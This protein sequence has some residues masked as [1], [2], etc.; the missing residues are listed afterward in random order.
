MGDIGYE[1]ARELWNEAKKGEK[2]IYRMDYRPRSGKISIETLQKIMLINEM[3]NILCC[4]AYDLFIKVSLVT[5][6]SN[7]MVKFSE[8]PLILILHR[9]TKNIFKLPPNSLVYKKKMMVVMG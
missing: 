4:N 5:S 2:I 3:K 7:K 9:V 8:F 6:M 1:Q